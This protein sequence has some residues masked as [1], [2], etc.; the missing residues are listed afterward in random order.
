MPLRPILTIKALNCWVID[1]MNPFPVYNGY[2]FIFI[3]I[4][5]VF[6]WLEATT[7]RRNEQQNVDLKSTTAKV[8]YQL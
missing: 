8:H 5:Y 6:K 3:T 7:G 4:D 2:I 1:F